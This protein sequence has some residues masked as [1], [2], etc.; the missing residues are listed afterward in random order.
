[1]ARKTPFSTYFGIGV[2]CVMECSRFRLKACDEAGCDVISSLLQDSI[3]HITSHSFHEDR[4]CLRLILNRFCWELTKAEEI[5]VDYRDAGGY[6]VHSGLYVYNVR[7]V[8][9]ND[10]FKDI[11]R[12]RYLNL[13]AMH[14][15]GGEINLLFSGHKNICLAVSDLRVYLK[16][17]HERYPTPTR[18]FHAI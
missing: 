12:E 5:G 17:L 14:A 13:L 6:R 7:N 10:N 9:V 16:D 11:T 3:F 1:M 18:S 2:V 8:T 15:N 4:Q